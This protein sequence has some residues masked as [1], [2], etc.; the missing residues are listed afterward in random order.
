MSDGE[1]SSDSDD[2]LSIPPRPR[3]R[4][5]T[6]FLAPGNYILL[7]GNDARFRF[8]AIQRIDRQDPEWQED[9]AVRITVCALDIGTFDLM[10]AYV[11]PF[12]YNENTNKFEF[13][14][15]DSEGVF[16]DPMDRFCPIE[17]LM[18]VPGRADPNFYP[19]DNVLAQWESEYNAD[20][21]EHE[22]AIMRDTEARLFVEEIVQ[23]ILWLT[24]R[25]MV[26]RRNGLDD[27]VNIKPLMESIDLEIFHRLA[28]QILSKVGEEWD[29]KSFNATYQIYKGLVGVIGV[30]REPLRG[31]YTL[32][33]QSSSSSSD[34]G[35]DNSYSFLSGDLNVGGDGGVLS[36]P[37]NLVQQSTP[38]HISN[39]PSDT[40]ETSSSNDGLSSFDNVHATESTHNNLHLEE[41]R[42]ESVR[43]KPLMK[44]DRQMFLIEFS[45]DLQRIDEER[46]DNYID[47]HYLKALKDK[48]V[49]IDQSQST[50]QQIIHQLQ[51]DV[52]LW[53]NNSLLRDPRVQSTGI[54]AAFDD[55]TLQTINI[56]L[57]LA[58]A[59]LNGGEI[60]VHQ[61]ETDV[62]PNVG[63]SSSVSSRSR[64]R[65]PASS[66]HRSNF[67]REQQAIHKS[68]AQIQDDGGGK[69]GSSSQPPS[70]EVDACLSTIG[71]VVS[72]TAVS[73]NVRFKSHFTF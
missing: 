66:S 71:E 47:R 59:N 14:V 60:V 33:D 38:T 43:E 21:R 31:Y 57:A 55:Q 61:S 32:P 19:D 56:P 26:F 35:E 8:V 30:G 34:S 22:E 65:S 15:S 52:K 45:A 44:L 29:K 40:I 13:I 62:S 6:R 20:N 54:L 17:S 27:M 46:L 25:A 23:R 72:S 18:L 41:M 39:L 28:P 53:Q 37:S 63:S 24:R 16:K 12:R 51:H 73:P 2:T 50:K 4:L 3:P 7:Q 10:E 11:C 9:N 64:S 67:V 58:A 49:E 36:D 70:N 69:V 68:I 1:S 42:E 5:E 48:P